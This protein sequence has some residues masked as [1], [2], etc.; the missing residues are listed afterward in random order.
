MAHKLCDNEQWSLEEVSST[1]SVARSMVFVSSCCR[2]EHQ[3]MCRPI[4]ISVHP[5]LV[6]ALENMLLFR[7]EST[8][9]PCSTCFELKREMRAVKS[10]VDKKLRYAEKYREPLEAQFLD[11]KLYY[12]LR[13]DSRGAQSDILT[14]II[15]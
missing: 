6:N 8:H 3:K 11:R 1:R 13:P 14:I 15:D 9:S 5:P 7:K 2:A 10:N 4:T 12:L